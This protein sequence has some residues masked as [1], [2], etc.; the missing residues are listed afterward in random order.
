MQEWKD[1]LRTLGRRMLQTDFTYFKLIGWAPFYFSTVLDDCS[2]Y[3]ISWK[4]CTTM[5]EGDVTDTLDLAL[6]A[7]GSHSGSH[8][9]CA[10][11]AFPPAE[12]VQD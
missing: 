2:R 4:L 10:R 1:A 9:P 8:E 11:P 3:I 12:A 7:S 6:T 5:T